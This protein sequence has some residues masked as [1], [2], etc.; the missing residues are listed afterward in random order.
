MQTHLAPLK[1]VSMPFDFTLGA[2]NEG[3]TEGWFL[4]PHAEN[5]A[6]LQELIKYAI[7]KHC[8]YRRKF[9]PEDPKIITRDIRKNPVF[10]AQIK[11]LRR[12]T[13][14][15]CKKLQFSAPIFSLRHQGHMLW[16][17]ALPAIVGYVAAM[18]YNQN[19]VAD[20]ASPVTT[21][22]EIAVGNDLCNML[23]FDVG[24]SPTPWGHIT[25]DGSV[26]NIESL[27]AARN[28]KFYPIALQSALRAEPQLAPARDLHIT[29][30]D[31][32]SQRLLDVSDVWTLLN[33]RV[34]DVVSLPQTIEDRFQVCRNV[35]NSALQ[36]YSV[37]NIG[38][39]DFYDRFV[40]GAIAPIAIAPATR[41]YSWPKAATLI[42][43]GQNNLIGVEVDLD[44]RMGI[45]KLT[46]ALDNALE[47]RQPV[48]SVVAVIGSTEESAVDPLADI[49]NLR[50]SF[51][52]KGLDFAI[53]A[54]AAWGGYFASML[55]P[56][57]DAI[58][59]FA[60]VPS[61]PMSPYVENQYRALAEADSI[62]VDPHK[63][64][65]VPYPAGGLCYRN[66]A[67]RDVISLRAPVVFHSQTEPT[68]GVYGVEGSKP[69][70]A[71]AAVWLAHKMIRP[72][73]Q[74]YGKILGQCI[75]T[76]KR[77]YCHF[78]TLD[79][80]RI[81]LTLVQR[82]PAE[83]A[84]AP[85]AQIQEQRDHIRSTFIPKTNKELK[86]YLSGNSADA[87]L[88]SQLGSDQVI[89]T[90]A[91]N[92]RDKNGRANR[93]LRKM[94]DLNDAVFKICST[95]DPSDD[96]NEFNKKNLILTSSSFDPATYGQTFVDKFIQRAQCMPAPG[97]AVNTLISTTMNPWTTDAPKTPNGDFLTVITDALRD[98][99]YKGMN[100]LGY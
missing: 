33:I 38:L 95:L 2:P 34:D 71:A 28:I 62:T 91:F 54:D 3:M 41:H 44:A 7:D 65:Y 63:A 57:E 76:S 93:D 30:L 43:I 15:L 48:L 18:L 79:D 31:G 51:R 88:F 89:L 99:V 35:T 77:M 17:Q 96:W 9:H 84:G 73:Q 39:L 8:E 75:W 1:S 27:W 26:A 61:A 70:A 81:I 4:G 80:P 12:L 23:G 14:A 97:V 98:A 46:D 94:N 66:S 72:T 69:G 64:G 11:T 58:Q 85:A 24:S 29:L 90:Y 67:M 13:Q 68:V 45:G 86:D 20:E 5:E 19:N 55:R 22:L 83:Q 40:K 60:W 36:N 78:A 32:S 53:H 21:Q 50:E 42:G 59:P 87:D 100:E 82:L 52:A 6:I 16:D 56:P 47:N 25:C 74:G 37:Q 10:K 49:L 92:F